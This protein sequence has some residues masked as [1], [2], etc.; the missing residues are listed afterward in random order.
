MTD[1]LP[2]ILDGWMKLVSQSLNHFLL[3]EGK[4]FSTQI[5]PRSIG[6]T[7]INKV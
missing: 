4:S 7:I 5:N 2:D 6:E 1:L 3:Y